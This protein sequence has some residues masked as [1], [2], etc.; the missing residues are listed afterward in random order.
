METETIRDVELVSTGTHAASTGTTKVT[1]EHLE[2]MLRAHADRAA[3]KAPVKLGHVSKLNNGIGEGAPAYGWVVP[4]RIVKNADGGKTL[5]G[6]LVGMPA[7]LAKVAPT[8]YRRRSVE[9]KWQAMTAAGKRYPAMLSAVALLGITEPAI[10]S[11]EDVLALYSSSDTIDADTGTIELVDGLEDNPAAV[12]MLTAARL[13]GATVE[14]LDAIAAAAGASDTANLPTPVADTVDDGTVSTTTQDTPTPTT[15]GTI[16]MTDDE[17][18]AALKLEADADVTAAITAL[19][20]ERTASTDPAPVE[21]APAAPATPAD[22]AAPVTPATPAEPEAPEVPDNAASLTPELATLSAGALAELS[23]DA[24]AYREHRRTKAVDDAV[25]A[26]KITPAE[27]ET[28]LASMAHDE[29]HTTSL[30]SSMAARFPTTE[31]GNDSAQLSAGNPDV[32]AA[33]EAFASGAPL[34]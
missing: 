5:L 15:G 19:L 29:T 8:A 17:L 6:N 13:S 4:T 9:I 21:P 26:G 14:Q 27:R 22:P 34:A 23:A 18:R 25:S 30:L 2:S 1:D 12:A 7:K 3:P 28:W 16:P 24:Q 20:E 33:L 11:L 10:N 32:D 31:V